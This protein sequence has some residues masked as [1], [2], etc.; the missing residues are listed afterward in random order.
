MK[1]LIKKIMK[2]LLTSTPIIIAVFITIILIK[3]KPQPGQ[4]YPG[5]ITR[6]LRVIEVPEI[7]IIPR[8][9]G[10]GIAKPE[11]IWKVISQVK[12]TIT[13]IHPRLKSG[14]LLPAGTEIIKIDPTEYDVTIARLKANIE[15]T[16]ANLKELE[17]EKDN[18]SQLI[19]IE[20][21]SLSLANKLLKR[22]Q[23]LYKNQTISKTE[24]DQEEKNYLVQQN[25]L[26][27]LQNTLTLIPVKIK[28]Q[29]ATLAAYQANLQQGKL[30]KE[31]TKITVPYNCR[32]GAVDIEA[33]QYVQAGQQLF[34]AHGT[35]ITEV[36]AQFRIDELRKFLNLSIDSPLDLTF[37]PKAFQKLFNNFKATV[38]LLSGDWSTSWAARID[39]LRESM[40]TTTRTMKVVVAVDD[41]YK[42]VIPGQK[43]PLTGGMFCEVE[44]QAPILKNIIIIPRSAIHNKSIYL[45][46]SENRLRKKNIVIDFEQADFAVI[47]EGLQPGQRIIVSDPTP[48]ILGMK[49]SPV[50][51][52]ELTEYLI[53]DSQ[54][55]VIE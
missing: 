33:G 29:E 44:L 23:K 4:N 38:Y 22:K 39:R 34:L 42:K 51:D 5:E 1:S 28:A 36:E 14:E 31:K 40:D 18:I 8:I 20:K 54:R 2:V 45:V 50:I 37:S 26:Q 16:R 17:K 46:D 41:P 6:I 30:D 24:L 11:S 25:T 49:I 47:K 9:T 53:T 10:Y 52:K 48:A 35:D 3:H 32:L 21:H 7:D 13:Y 15:T 43:P 19:Q 27:Q 12:G 55:K